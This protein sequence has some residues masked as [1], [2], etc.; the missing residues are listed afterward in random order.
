MWV[1]NE[2]K[3]R[4][5]QTREKEK[6]TNNAACGLHAAS[7]NEREKGNEQ[8]GMWVAHRIVKREGKKET[9]DAARG[10]HTAS[11]NEREKRK[12]MTQHVDC[13]PRR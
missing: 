4:H 9:N 12:Q 13:T 6:G 5:R 3:G 1:L 7:S 8:H 10:L 11:L 2:R